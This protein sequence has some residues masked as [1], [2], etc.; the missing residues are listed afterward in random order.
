MVKKYNKD[1]ALKREKKEEYKK[2]SYK[3]ESLEKDIYLPFVYDL[4]SLFLI[5]FKYNLKN[6]VMYFVD[7]LKELNSRIFEMCL[8][9][10]EDICINILDRCLKNS[11]VKPSYIHF[12]ISKKHELFIH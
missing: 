5:F 4:E 8:A 9:F 6:V 11:N 10:D 7:N 12:C 1:P 2:L 3:L